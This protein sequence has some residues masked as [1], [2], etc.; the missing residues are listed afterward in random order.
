MVMIVPIAVVPMVV[1]GVMIGHRSDRMTG[2]EIIR[3][4]AG[5]VLSGRVDAIA[6][7]AIW[8]RGPTSRAATAPPLRHAAAAMSASRHDPRVRPTGL[9]RNIAMAIRP[10]RIYQIFLHGRFS[11]REGD[12]ESV[13][14][15]HNLRFYSN[16][17]PNPRSLFRELDCRAYED[18]NYSAAVAN[19]IG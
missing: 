9:A 5:R 13:M 11:V 18:C 19:R 4:A 6:A 8:N 7:D 15:Q 10:N 3:M 14:L 16:T 1:V 17:T 12:A 2:V